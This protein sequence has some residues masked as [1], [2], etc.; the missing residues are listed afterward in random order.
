MVLEQEFHKQ[1]LIFY[2]TKPS[3]ADQVEQGEAALPPAGEEII[4]D[5]KIVTEY[6]VNNEGKKIKVVRYYKIECKKVS[7]T[8]ARRKLWKKF[9]TAADDP[10]GPNPSNTIVS[11]DIFMQFLTNKEEEQQVEEDP[12]AKIRGQKM[13]KCRICK[14]D[15]W[16]TQCPFKDKLGAL[17]DLLKDEATPATPSPQVEEKVKAGKYVP[18]IMREGANR[19]GESMTPSRTRDE[20]ATIRVTN[21][22]EDVRDSDLQELFRPFGSIARIYLA[23]DKATGHSK[24]FAFINFHR[25]EDAAHA[26]SSVNG[27]GYDNLILSVEWAKPSGSS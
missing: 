6:K 9:G 20:T 24:G 12:L 26:I 21:L 11:E 7:K 15:H 17:P 10:P 18:P 23:K 27:F 14:E 13:V 3:W 2:E 1:H 16:T 19:R 8:V 5:T 22:S 4:G 25:R